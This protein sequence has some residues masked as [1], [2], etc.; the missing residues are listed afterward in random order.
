MYFYP[1]KNAFS[2]FAF[3]LIVKKFVSQQ[4]EFAFFVRELT[5][6]HFLFVGVCVMSFVEKNNFLPFVK[7]HIKG[8]IATVLVV[9]VMAGGWFLVNDN[10]SANALRKCRSIFCGFKEGYHSGSI[11]EIEQ[12]LELLEKNVAECETHKFFLLPK[13]KEELSVY[14]KFLDEYPLETVR[15]RLE[16]C[17]ELDEL[18]K[19]YNRSFDELRKTGEKAFTNEESVTL[20]ELKSVVWGLEQSELAV[21]DKLQK[22]LDVES[23]SL[24][25]TLSYKTDTIQD[26][27]DRI[28]RDNVDDYT[29]VKARSFYHI[30]YDAENPTEIISD[31]FERINSWEVNPFSTGSSSVEFGGTETI[32]GIKEYCADNEIDVLYC[33]DCGILRNAVAYDEVEK[34]LSED[35]IAELLN[36]ISDYMSE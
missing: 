3:I 21:K 27:I 23:I 26:L 14:R 32:A 12:E 11:E 4:C 10:L 20:K 7:R 18:I 1:D 29:A 24:S 15:Q 5:L 9:A 28:E 34:L 17:D 25:D 19:A 30:Y 2:V 35:E 8:I 31:E 33:N 22:I 16:E 36:Y 6:A 13:E